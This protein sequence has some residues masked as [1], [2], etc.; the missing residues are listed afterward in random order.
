MLYLCPRNMG[1]LGANMVKLYT[2]ASVIMVS[3]KQITIRLYGALGS[4][5]SGMVIV[6]WV[7]LRILECVDLCQLGL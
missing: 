5:L 4:V 1:R 2:R 6:A 3:I 7:E